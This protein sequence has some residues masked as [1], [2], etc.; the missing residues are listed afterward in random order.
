MDVLPRSPLDLLADSVVGELLADVDPAT[1]RLLATVTG[2]DPDALRAVVL[3][4]LGLGVLAHREPVGR[5]CPAEL[6]EGPAGAALNAL[7]KA[8]AGG[9]GPAQAERTSLTD[10]QR[11]ILALL[12]DGLTGQAIAHRLR[13]SPRTVGKHLERIYRRLGTSDRL[14]A[15]LRAQH[16]GLLGSARAAGGYRG[17]TSGL[18][19]G[20]TSGHTSAARPR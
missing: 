12:S 2:P 19:P 16:C 17:L 9:G 1:L 7:R 6:T 13:L 8:F 4:A 5:A 11:Q 15:V 3:C 10:R 18:A 20:S 14:T